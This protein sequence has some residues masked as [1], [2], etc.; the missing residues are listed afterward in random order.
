MWTTFI[1]EG[2]LI[3]LFGL[4]GIFGNISLIRLFWKKDMKLNF[5][6]L[7]ISLAITDTIFI[8]LSIAMFSLPEI[9]KD[10]KIQYFFHMIPFAIPMMQV[11]LTGSIYFTVC[12]SIERY[13][14]VCHP[15]YLAA[16]TWSAKRYI[17]PIVTFS[18]LYNCVRFFEMRT[19]KYPV[20]WN[21]S[22]TN[23]STF[24]A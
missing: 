5:H 21:N 14:T 12:I 15:F 6:Q 18:L 2:I 10:Y 22:T 16:R 9:C 1:L 24:W 17:I 20:P 8:L 11:V 4:I 3:I 13:L 23:N 19:T 7:M